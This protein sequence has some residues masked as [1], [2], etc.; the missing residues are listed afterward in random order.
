MKSKGLSVVGVLEQRRT[1]AVVRA[2]N[3][4]ARRGW[5]DREAFSYATW[6]YRA[7]TIRILEA[8]RLHFA[9]HWTD[10]GIGRAMKVGGAVS[11][12]MV[13]K[14]RRQ[15]IDGYAWRP[16]GRPKK[17]PPEAHTIVPSSSGRHR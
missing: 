9:E 4:A 8:R 6:T 3:T 12:A 15:D 13:R 14:V 11:G 17:G 2:L 5:S 1:E 16:A 7:W 10:D